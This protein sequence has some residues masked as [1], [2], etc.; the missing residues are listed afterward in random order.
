MAVMIVVAVG[1]GAALWLTAGPPSE[2]WRLPDLAT[3]RATLT[4]SEIADR[5]LI[6]MAAALAWLVLG[7]LAVTVTLRCAALAANRAT[8]GARWARIA[9][10]LTNL[11]TVPAVRRIVD[12]GVAGTLLVASWMPATARVVVAAEPMVS[13]PVTAVAQAGGPARHAEQEPERAQA[14]AYT[15]V[16]G[17]DLWGIARRAYGDGSRYVE[18]FEAN[19]DRVMADGER[20]TDPRVIRVGWVLHLPLPSQR[21]DVESGVP[22]YRTLP[23]DHLWGIAERFL[24]DGFRWTELW[25]ANRDREMG[26]GWRFTNPNLIYPGW[27]IAL[28]AEVLT[29]APAVPDEAAP[30]KPEVTATP[31]ATPEAT[32]DPA[33]DPLLSSDDAAD[34]EGGWGI[35]WDWPSTPRPLVITSAGFAVLGT[36]V[37]FVSRLRRQGLL[38][39]PSFRRNA[40][41]TG[42]AGRIALVGRVVANA[43]ADAGH[44]DAR[45]LLIHEKERHLT[46]TVDCPSGNG[47]ALAASGAELSERLGCAVEGM[48]VGAKRVNL[49]LSGIGEATLRQ[50]SATDAGQAL[51]LPVGTEASGAIVYLNLA[52]A[53]SVAVSGADGDRRQLL[54]SWLSTLAATAGADELALCADGIAAA[55][56]GD[57]LDLP[58][59]GGADSPD[60]DALVEELED[61]IRSREGT[62]MRR[63]LV[64]VLDAGTAT[65]RADA[66]IPYAPE[67]G[68]YVVGLA[69][70]DGA[71]DRPGGMFGAVVRLGLDAAAGDTDGDGI[72]RGSVRLTVGSGESLW[73]DPVLVRRDASPRW[74]AVIPSRGDIDAG[75]VVDM[76]K[77]PNTDDEGDPTD[78]GLRAADTVASAPFDWHRALFEPV[79]APNGPPAAESCEAAP[80]RGGDPLVEP[81]VPTPS[82]ADAGGP[83]A[84]SAPDPV[85]EPQPAAF[86]VADAAV[87]ERPELD[88]GPRAVGT[89]PSPAA[90]AEP[91]VVAERQQSHT[92]SPSALPEST[93]HPPAGEPPIA[94]ADHQVRPPPAATHS[95]IVRQ[96]PLW[97]AETPGGDAADG[98]GGE[99]LIRVRCFGEFE[100]SV[101]GT[102]VTNWRYEKGREFVAL[103]VA[104][105]GAPVPRK[106]VAELLWPELLWDSSVKHM[107]DN[108]AT[109]ARKA[110]R[111][112]AGQNDLQ[113]ITLARDRYQFQPGILQSDLDEFDAAVRRAAGLPAADALEQYARAVALYRGD[114]MQ[115]EAFE[116]LDRFRPEYHRRFLDAARA[117]AGLA[118]ELGD[119]ERAAAFY[120]AGMERAP[121][122]EALARGLMRCRGALG[123]PSG[124]HKVYQVLTEAL[125]RELGIPSAVPSAET[126]ALREELVGATVG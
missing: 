101:A 21:I 74:R 26:A 78:P 84:E 45:L 34:P 90:A 83:P 47:E 110:I 96:Q 62:R 123:D 111:V 46:C 85:A 27:E 71:H 30:V 42:D 94:P 53:G 56:A 122:D 113:P 1:L 44:P 102:S 108:A 116:W 104:H 14:V 57:D 91:V 67:A 92:A 105:G 125:Q 10:R 15:V 51:M 54:H 100:V 18:L 5:D 20:F 79:A 19:R 48:L 22:T 25:E 33:A 115:S 40:W 107:M 81:A 58:H 8:R 64:A 39:L 93:V 4:A 124:V 17:D 89:E 12:G 16:R 99:A 69:P 11:I 37:L 2:A 109:T 88:D 29:V 75:D 82:D 66:I 95:P 6:A 121:T 117:A 28:P 7:Y 36:A 87:E 23:G 9:L 119:V 70:S 49:V 86:P 72:E 114:V 3:V 32:P 103:L 35:A 59:F 68:V 50:G 63:P 13:L 43:V 31:E 76:A 52:G 120:S 80:G 60:T 24:G 38:Q 126:R 112:A 73:L 118:A 61:V 65:A 77:A 41:A 55:L 97:L 106:V 98:E